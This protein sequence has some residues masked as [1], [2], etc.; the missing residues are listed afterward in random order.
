MQV[1]IYQI[2]CLITDKIYV[3]GSNN[4]VRRKGE[5]YWGLR[6]NKHDNSRLQSAWNEHGEENFSFEIIELVELKENLL[7]REQFYIDTTKCA[8]PNYGYNISPNAAHDMNELIPISQLD[9]ISLDLIENFDSI[10]Q[11]EIALGGEECF[12]KDNIGACVRGTQKTAYGYRW[13]KQNEQ[14][15]NINDIKWHPMPVIKYDLV[16]GEVLKIYKGIREAELIEQQSKDAGIRQTCI[17]RQKSS[18]G[19]GW[20]YLNDSTPYYCGI[21]PGHFG[22]ITLIG[23]KQT[24]FFTLPM[25]GKEYNIQAISLFFRSWKSN[26]VHA[27][28]EHVHAIQG[29]IGNTSNFNF[30]L[31]KGM[32][33]SLLTAYEIPHTLV[34]PQTWQKELHQGVTKVDDKK[35]MSSI[36]AKRLFPT[37]DFRDPRRKTERAQKEHDGLIDSLLIAEYTRRMFSK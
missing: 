35:M 28:L 29:R 23:Q 7:D 25:I 6:H 17:K 31:G 24:F 21:D 11:A 15:P 16:T 27:G 5:H 32:L 36:A 34:P 26:I 3:G 4:I 8:H 20:K 19:F 9:Y 33:M 30:G 1:G 22:C 12:S 14:K 13:I 2:K 18:L 37:H 10:Q